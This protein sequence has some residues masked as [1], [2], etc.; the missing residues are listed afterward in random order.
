MPLPF[1]YD[2]PQN[3]T[4]AAMVALVARF[5]EMSPKPAALADPIVTDATI[6]RHLW[7]WIGRIGSALG[8]RAVLPLKRWDGALDGACIDLAAR[9]VYNTRGRNRQAGADVEIDNVSADALAYLARL[10]PGGDENGKTENP[11]FDDAQSNIPED[12]GLFRRGER[13]DSWVAQERGTRC[14]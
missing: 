9:S 7:K 10:A 2:V 12:R 1:L 14:L 4:D 8:D 6:A 5:R 13:S 3:P 11:L